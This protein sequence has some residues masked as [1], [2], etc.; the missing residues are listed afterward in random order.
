MAPRVSQHSSG[1]EPHLSRLAAAASDGAVERLQQAVCQQP[2]AALG[3][4]E[5]WLGP[6]A[7]EG[8]Q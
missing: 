3:V 1:F 6:T 5:Y 4:L 7:D 8:N 2:E